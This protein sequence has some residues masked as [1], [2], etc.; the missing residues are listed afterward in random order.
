M[1][2]FRPDCLGGMWYDVDC[3]SLKNMAVCRV[4]G[5]APVMGTHLEVLSSLEPLIYSAA[6][7]QVGL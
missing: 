1:N 5:P 7:Y 6:K 4:P 2:G 3:Q